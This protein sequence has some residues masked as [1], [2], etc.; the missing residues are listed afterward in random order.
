MTCVTYVPVEAHKRQKRTFHHN[1]MA[2]QITPTSLSTASLICCKFHPKCTVATCE[3]C[4]EL[5]CSQC[6]DGHHLTHQTRPLALYYDACG[7]L[8][9]L[10]TMAQQRITLL[11]DT[12]RNIQLTV[13]RLKTKRLK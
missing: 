2:V 4:M 12:G 9:D 5:V 13:S 1:A 3:D 11:N 10:L 7:G 8:E 6:Y